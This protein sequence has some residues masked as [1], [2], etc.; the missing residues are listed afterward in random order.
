MGLPIDFY[1]EL[2]KLALATELSENSD[3]NES[4]IQAFLQ[5]MCGGLEQRVDGNRRWRVKRMS[6]SMSAKR[7]V[8]LNY[9]L[10]PGGLR[11]KNEYGGEWINFNSTVRDIQIAT[12]GR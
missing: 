8:T 9:L 7:F 11:D 12:H 10:V 5:T 2:Y 1:Q 6:G 4:L 3:T